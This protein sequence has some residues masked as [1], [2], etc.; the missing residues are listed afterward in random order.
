VLL[1]FGRCCS[2]RNLL[3]HHLV[4]HLPGP[5]PATDIHF[6]TDT[7][8]TTYASS[9]NENSV[10]TTF[11]HCSGVT[12]QKKKRKSECDTTRVGGSICTC[13]SSSSSSGSSSGRLTSHPL[14]L[15]PGSAGEVH[16][17]LP[18]PIVSLQ[19]QTHKHPSQL[20]KDNDQLRRYMR[21]R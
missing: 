9:M 19:T 14:F 5:Q 1:L 4:C 20:M 8:I 2:G 21:V 6:T 3:L 12:T 13:S 11:T 7:V 10:M 15:P 18:P 17:I 16:R